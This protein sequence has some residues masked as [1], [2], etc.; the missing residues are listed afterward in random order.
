[1][2][3]VFSTRTNGGFTCA[4]PVLTVGFPKAP[5]SGNTVVLAN[6]A[7]V[8]LNVLAQI[9]IQ[10]CPGVHQPV[11]PATTT[12]DDATVM[13]MAAAMAQTTSPVTMDATTMMNQA[14]MANMMA[15]TNFENAMD[16]GDGFGP[17]QMALAA[18]M[19]NITGTM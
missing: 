16:L 1:V 13:A 3:N 2:S 4:N 7:V 17:D 5:T 12:L 6:G 18:M 14:I 9:V 10:N 8:D 19:A 11:Q 15:Q